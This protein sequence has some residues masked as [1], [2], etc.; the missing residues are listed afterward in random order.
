MEE[1]H[2]QQLIVAAVNVNIN[3][4]FFQ[5]YGRN[6]VLS[7]V[8]LDVYHGEITVLLGHNGA[9][10]T[11][12]M[13]II[14]SSLLATKGR[15]FV[16]G[17]DIA[18]D[19]SKQ[20]K[21]MI[22]TCTQHNT[23]YSRLTVMEH[24][25]L[26]AMLRGHNFKQSKVSSHYLLTQLGLQEKLKNRASELSGGMQRRLQLACALAGDCKVLIL[27][28][29]TS[30]LDVETRRELWTLLMSLR[31]DKTILLTTHFMEEADALGDRVAA[32]NNGRLK[33]HASPM[34]LKK[35]VGTGYRVTLTTHQKIP[36]ENEIT[37]T[38]QKVIPT[39][40]VKESSLHSISYNLP[41]Q[42]IEEYATVFKAL[43]DNKENLGIESI[44]V[45]SSSLEEVFMA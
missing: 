23:F 39:A 19:K 7:N 45:G 5:I 28:E 32:L 42:E 3:I 14:T 9:G 18:S 22:G 37:E 10:K 31:G 1:V 24:V 11:T 43:E 26:F 36:K 16:N 34:Y 6:I 35:N 44:G 38:I 20:A 17:N 8:T 21:A 2:F 25:R 15:V 41:S 33:C 13:S 40:T 30:G 4:I 12:L 29:P 27:D